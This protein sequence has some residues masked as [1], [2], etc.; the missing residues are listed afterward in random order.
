MTQTAVRSSRFRDTNNGHFT[1]ACPR[2]CRP[3]PP[4]KEMR[5][6][7][8]DERTRSALKSYKH[9]SPD[10]SYLEELYLNSF[11]DAVASTYPA[12][13][14]PNLLTCM[15]VRDTLLG[16][17]FLFQVCGGGAGMHH[18][19]D[20]FGPA[21]LFRACDC[22]ARCR[23]HA[24]GS[25]CQAV[26]WAVTASLCVGCRDRGGVVISVH[27]TPVLMFCISAP[28]HTRYSDGGFL[29]QDKT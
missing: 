26:P 10:L 11:W 9:V 16:R 7:G 21:L 5:K 24:C 18:C 4:T 2:T 3:H 13:L 22:L 14:A 23:V 8:D 12:W 27:R 28:S 19:L 20:V 25:Q 1:A 17:V 15:S 29:P 6:S